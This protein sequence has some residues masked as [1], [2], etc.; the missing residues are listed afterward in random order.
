MTIEEAQKVANPLFDTYP[1]VNKFFVTSDEQAFEDAHSAYIHAKTLIYKDV[2]PVWR[3]AELG[4][5]KEADAI[6]NEK[7]EDNAGDEA[8]KEANSVSEID[9]VALP[10]LIPVAEEKIIK[11]T[12]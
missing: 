1:S 9:T 3:V 5:T 10:D 8:E 7:V 11:A 4:D 6:D 2:V 12:K